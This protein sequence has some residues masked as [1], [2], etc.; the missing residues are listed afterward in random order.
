MMRVIPYRPVMS[1]HHS[2]RC[3][4]DFWVLWTLPS[5]LSASYTIVSPITLRDIARFYYYI[6]SCCVT[7]VDWL[8]LI[9]S[10]FPSTIFPDKDE[11]PLYSVYGKDLLHIS[12]RY[13]GCLPGYTEWS[14]VLRDTIRYSPSVLILRELSI[15]RDI[16][17]CLA[18][19]LPE[20]LKCIAR[21]GRVNNGGFASSDIISL[22][23]HS[24]MYIFLCHAVARQLWLMGFVGGLARIPI[25][26]L[27]GKLTY[28]SQKCS[29][30][31]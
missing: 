22:A 17:G 6:P 12:W 19:H 15:D 16:T 24:M 7:I 31:C 2:M 1:L 9:D 20:V 28:I 4:S 25:H 13:K 10:E 21:I 23:S 11:S 27:V 30:E 26:M 8:L 3:Y 5:P 18:K 29:P 14:E